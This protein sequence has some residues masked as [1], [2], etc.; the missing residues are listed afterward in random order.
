[1]PRGRRNQASLAVVSPGD[2]LPSIT[3]VDRLD[4]VR[5]IIHAFPGGGKTSL[6]GSG[7]ADG[8][9]TLIVRS[10]MDLIP[11]RVLVASQQ[12][13][14]MIDQVICDRWEKMYEVLD[15]CRMAV[16]FP[17]DWVWWDNI[18]VAE[19]VLL[20]D[21]WEGT[22][23]AN[24]KRAYLIDGN[25]KVTGPNLNPTAGLDRGEYGRNMERIQQWV[26]HMVGVNRFHFGIM[27]HPHE[28]QH[29]TNDEGGTLLRPYVQGKMMSEK[30]CGYANLVGFMEVLEGDQ[31]KTW[32]RL[33]VRES[34]RWYAK[35]QYDAFPKGYVDEPT[36][37]KLMR[38]IA[39]SKNAPQSTSRGRGSHGA[40]A[41][42]GRGTRA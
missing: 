9:R 26:R 1:V 18:S 15:Y 24:P 12:Y 22:I 42:R 23:A 31:G 3:P 13:P 39:E 35:D 4:W 17:Y 38:A 10:P 14:G 19:D 40:T 28:G 7:A 27:A 20:D 6:I 32:R 21:V 41:G 16:D 2:G 36:M 34:A 11:K 37:G 29:P 30:I 8:I 5:C 33:H 25:G